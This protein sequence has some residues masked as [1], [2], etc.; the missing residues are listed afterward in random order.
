MI[1]AQV[2]LN[3]RHALVVRIGE[4]G[5]LSEALRKVAKQLSKAAEQTTNS[6]ANKRKLTDKSGETSTK[7]KKLRS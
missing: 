6:G 3:K 2:S 4:K 7:A 5:I 1:L